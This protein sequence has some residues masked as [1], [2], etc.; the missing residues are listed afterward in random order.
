MV[1]S[2]LPYRL[3]ELLGQHRAV[4]EAAVA[5]SEPARRRERRELVAT[6][7]HARLDRAVQLYPRGVHLG[8]FGERGLVVPRHGHILAHGPSAARPCVHEPPTGA[9]QL[10]PGQ[11][12]RLPPG[13]DLT[14][15]DPQIDVLLGSRPWIEPRRGGV[16]ILERRVGA[17]RDRLDEPSTMATSRVCPSATRA[18]SA[19]IRFRA[20]RLARGVEMV[21]AAPSQTKDSGTRYALPS[22]S[23]EATQRSTSSRSRART[24]AVRCSR[25]ATARSSESRQPSLEEAPLGVGVD[26][27]ERALVRGARLVRRGRA[28]AGGRPASRGGSG[29]RRARAGRRRPSAGLDVARLGDRDRAVEL[30][31]RR[32]GAAGELAVERRDLRPVGRLVRRAARRSP[33]AARTAPRPPSASARSSA[34]RPAAI[35]L[36][37]PE[38]AVLVARGGRRS[39]SGEA[40]ARGARR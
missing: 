24:S 34:A 30:D 9:H 15:R 6:K 3:A 2:D 1:Q 33:P 16:G 4:R 8:S 12:V 17:D 19:R 22:A 13:L 26:E 23:A 36:G 38:R 32:A 27:L 29:S 28:G 25:L 20:V 14:R 35:S 7:V 37:V 31:D 39:P 40:R 18:H 21:R 11:L 5:R 10:P